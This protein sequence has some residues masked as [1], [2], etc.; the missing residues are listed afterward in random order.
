[1]KPR[2]EIVVC[3]QQYNSIKAKERATPDAPS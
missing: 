3:Y 2:W 1:M